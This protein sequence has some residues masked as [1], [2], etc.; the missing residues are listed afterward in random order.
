MPV[1]DLFADGIARG[2]KTHDGSRLEND[3]TLETDVV[4]VGSG[5][6][7]GTSAE[8]LSAAGLKV[9]IVEEGPLKTSTDFR[10][11][12]SEAYPALYQE[13]IGR[14]SKD[15]AVTILQ[16]RAVGGTTLINWTSSFRTPEPTLEH[17]AREHGVR[18]LSASEM[19]P[20]FERMEQRLGV[21]PWAMPPNANNDVLRAGCEKLGY[22][23][24]VIPRNVKAAG[25]SA[26]AAWAAR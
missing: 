6:G 21:Q 11:Q 10:M 22:H 13:G 17:W 25:I 26:T 2:W 16:G 8:I 19:A 9:L 12:E 18:G 15:G 20:W 7:G 3:L 5:A 23:W 1:P 4:I 14:M 24:A